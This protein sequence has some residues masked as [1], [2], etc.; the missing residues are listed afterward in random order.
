MIGLVIAGFVYMVLMVFVYAQTTGVLINGSETVKL[1]IAKDNLVHQFSCYKVNP[2]QTP[3]SIP[4]SVPTTITPTLQITPTSISGEGTKFSVNLSGGKEVPAN[5]SVATGTANFILNTTNNT[6]M[7]QITYQNLSSAETG[8]HIHGPAA[9][10][11][12][13][14]TVHNLPIGNNK[15][16][17]WTYNEAQEADL[18]N[19]QMY[20]NIHT[21]NYPDG[22]IRGQITNIDTPT[23]TIRPTNTPTQ[24][25]SNIPTPT[26]TRVQPSPTSSANIKTTIVTLTGAKEVPAT[27][28]T[29]TGTAKI[30]L[31]LD[32][33]VLTYEL[34]FSG[35]QGTQTEAHIHGPSSAT[36]Q[37]P[38]VVDIAVGSPQSGSYDYPQ[39]V[40]A[41][42]LAGKYYIH[43]HS[44]AYLGGEIR[45]QIE[46]N[47]TGGNTTGQLQLTNVTFDTTNSTAYFRKPQNSDGGSKAKLPDNSVSINQG[48]VA[49]RVKTGFS[50]S[51]SLNR[52]PIFWDMTLKDPGSYQML[53][54]D[55]GSKTFHLERNNTLSSTSI[56][57]TSG[58][59]ITVVSAWTTAEAKISVNGGSFK[60]STFPAIPTQFPLIIGSSENQV[61][62]GTV[63]QPNSHYYWVAA[64]TGTLTNADAQTLHNFGNNDP[65][66]AA[67]PG[68]PVFFWDA[69]SSTYQK[70]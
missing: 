30:T 66:F 16:G 14:G 2:T 52:D 37:A 50:S 11:R 38:K 27:S 25:P 34:S 24:I 54:Y 42:L 17:T 28:S 21:Q 19:G 13:A 41:D 53:Y 18:L 7:Y 9:L 36:Q 3:S 4:S 51:D 44:T 35:L 31:N 32:T 67:L 65:T 56:P 39:S 6:L 12:T 40:E 68:S 45:A 60:S 15:V 64:G 1:N 59:D 33:N 22:E 61:P 69:T 48:W 63:R 62:D 58:T 10:N 55:M 46:F 23:L 8:T 26:P 49:V 5:T 43:I 47:N 20:I 70:S 29:A 57:F